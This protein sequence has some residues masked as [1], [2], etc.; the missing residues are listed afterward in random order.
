IV[1]RRLSSDVA[2]VP[3][4]MCLSNFAFAA[5]ARSPGSPVPWCSCAQGLLQK[6]SRDFTATG[7]RAEPQTEQVS[8]TPKVP[9]GRQCPATYVRAGLADLVFSGYNV[10]TWVATSRAGGSCR[11]LPSR[12]TTPRPL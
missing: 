7:G 5:L 6:G 2:V 11:A 3:S 1:S 10:T 8:T 12:P 9:G 4:S